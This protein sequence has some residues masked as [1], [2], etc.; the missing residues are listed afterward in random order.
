MAGRTENY[1]RDDAFDAMRLVLRS[2][3]GN[4]Y[5]EDE[6]LLEKQHAGRAQHVSV[7]HDAVARGFFSSK[8]GKKKRENGRMY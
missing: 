8:K 5:P 7:R 3:H 1:R 6:P 4:R 2:N